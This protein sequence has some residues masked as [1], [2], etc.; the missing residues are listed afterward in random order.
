MSAHAYANSQIKQQYL[1][2]HF[3]YAYKADVF[4]NGLSIIRTIELH[5]KSYLSSLPEIELYKKT[6]ATDEDKSAGDARLL[7]PLLKDYFHKHSLID[8]KT[9]L[10]YAAFDSIY[11]YKSLL[12][13]N[14]F[15]HTK[16]GS[17]L[18]FEKGQHS[19]KWTRQYK[20]QIIPPMRKLFRAALM[21]R[22][23]L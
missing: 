18:I 21:I 2:D 14:T 17:P 3:C 20:K 11:T 23:F 15:G 13:E 9:F 12:V 22:D 19:I 8:S 7:L 4:T 16:D 1:I 10:G 6:D 5:D